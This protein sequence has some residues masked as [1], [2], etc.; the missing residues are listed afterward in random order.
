MKNLIGTMPKMQ[1]NFELK[2]P[3]KD[4]LLFVFGVSITT[5]W[6]LIPG[7]LQSP[8]LTD[9]MLIVMAATA[10]PMTRRAQVV[11]MSGVAVILVSWI[12]QMF[13]AEQW[14]DPAE[15]V[16]YGRWLASAVAAAGLVERF[17]TRDKTLRIFMSGVLAGV[18]LH[19]V[20][21]FFAAAGLRDLLTA[22]GLAS[23]R[24]LVSWA[25]LQVRYT[26]VAEHP[27]LA[28]AL[29]GLA[30]PA[31]FCLSLTSRK[32]NYGPYRG[33]TVMLLALFLLVAGF[34]FTLSRAALLAGAMSFLF[35]LIARRDKAAAA[36]P[37]LLVLVMTAS[38]LIA[39]ALGF[40]FDGTRY[41]SRIDPDRLAQNLA[42]RG[43]TSV[44][45]LLSA[46]A[47]PFGMGW[48]AYLESTPLF[49]VLRASHNG[50][51]FAA[52]TI[53]LPVAMLILVG[54]LMSAPLSHKFRI[55]PLLVYCVAIMFAEDITQG[56]SFTF[57]VTLLAAYGWI[58]DLHGDRRS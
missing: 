22:I 18:V 52:R 2:T 10:F 36:M 25:A 58:G 15:I 13:A 23:P 40:E 51:L 30:V 39:P 37:F 57:L 17:Q 50:Y 45:A 12:L 49:G 54:H 4:A 35:Y 19:V 33:L 34:S 53:G 8:R 48:S 9:L 14:P 56:A 42:G 5:P 38:L 1:Q 41:A 7:Q 21:I 24:A 11:A 43:E 6:L 27:N 3:V 44:Q 20:S 32:L 26:T 29:V 47:R 46:F 28:M 55:S 16:F 31:A